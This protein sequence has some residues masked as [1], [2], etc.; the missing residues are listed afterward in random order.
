M[1]LK[2][3]S[4]NYSTQLFSF[5]LL[6]NET[7]IYEKRKKFTLFTKNALNITFEIK[8]TLFV[9]YYSSFFAN[10]YTTNKI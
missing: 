3:F 6:S 2:L 7:T 9:R 8:P 10:T 1:Y 5:Y 4:C